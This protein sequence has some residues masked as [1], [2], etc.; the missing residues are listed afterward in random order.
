VRVSLVHGLLALCESSLYN[1][2]LGVGY[3]S[4]PPQSPEEE[5]GEDLL[6]S[7]QDL[8]LLVVDILGPGVYPLCRFKLVEAEGD[9]LA[10]EVDVVDGA[11]EPEAVLVLPLA[12]LLRNIAGLP[13][14]LLP[15]GPLYVDGVLYYV[16]VCWV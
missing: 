3:L 16:P 13:F 11:R 4:P 10:E 14:P 5:L 15:L 9:S 7:I 8:P 12:S 1:L 6:E 2:N